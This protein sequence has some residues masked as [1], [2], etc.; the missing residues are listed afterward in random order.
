MC[1]TMVALGNSTK[2]GSVLFA[3]NSDRDFNEA[4][5]LELI[6][7]KTY[8]KGEKVKSTYIQIPQVNRT[9]TI[10]LSKPFWIWGAEMGANEFGVVIGN[11]AVFTKVGDAKTERLI[12]MDL[13]RL[14]LERS[15]SAEE[16]LHVIIDLLETHGQGGN[17]SFAHQLY[18]DNSYLIA[19]KKEAWVLETAGKQWAAEKVKDI[20]SISNILTIETKWDLASKD[21]IQYAVDR[22]WCK[23]RS[24]FNF[25]R[26]YSDFIYTTFGAGGARHACIEEFLDQRK[27]KLE[28][29][30]MMEALRTHGEDKKS[31][32]K[33][34]KA[35]INGE[36]CMHAGFGPAR[37]SQTTGSLVSELTS[38]ST[39]HWVTGTSAPCTSVFKPI[40]CEGGVPEL[41]PTPKGIFTPGSL[42]WEH[43]KLHRS[44]LKDYAT[45]MTKYQP[46]RD[47]M[48]REFAEKLAKSKIATPGQKKQYS[49]SCFS[50]EMG[51]INPW[52]DTIGR[53]PLESH[54]AF[55]YD[56]MLNS[57]NKAAN[58]PLE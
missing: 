32:W 53:L 38:R 47:A 23:N 17:C 8:P 4:Q 5:Y 6:E 20:R 1:D 24:Q 50:K 56:A 9:N 36:V 10:L 29:I 45:R 11:E 21:L 54:N 39:I 15:K 18:Y 3:K 41:G 19:D 30:A 43:E 58:F 51:K 57:I 31:G 22:G 37:G 44:I 13:L 35:L 49:A 14:A 28:A 16:A 7:G 46:E 40:W 52:V 26:C 48:Q 33:P 34:D 27:G 25:R 12:G 2:N 55:Y 42:W